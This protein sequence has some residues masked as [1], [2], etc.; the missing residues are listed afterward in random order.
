MKAMNIGAKLTILW[1][2]SGDPGPTTID[3]LTNAI[4]VRVEAAVA[5]S[6]SGSIDFFR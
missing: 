1:R 5:G 2:L 6:V 3:D 4:A